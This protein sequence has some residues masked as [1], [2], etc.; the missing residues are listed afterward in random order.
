[1]LRL[2]TQNMRPVQT[3]YRGLGQASTSTISTDA[4]LVSSIVS[5]FSKL[6]GGSQH[7]W[8]AAQ[9]NAESQIAAIVAAYVAMKNTNQLTQNYIATAMTNVAS[10]SKA[11]SQYAATFNNSGAN[12]GASQIASNANAVIANMESDLAALPVNPISSLISSI[13]GTNSGAT[14]SS[15]ITTTGTTATTATGQPSNITP[16]V[17]PVV[18]SGLLSSLS[19]PSYLAMAGIAYFL[20]FR[21]K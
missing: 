1:M 9:N 21:K 8:I 2:T 19:T 3:A 12:N 6:F 20:F 13:L 4:G 17:T 15:S 10:I 11:F 18:T 14:I 16:T 5:A 7:P